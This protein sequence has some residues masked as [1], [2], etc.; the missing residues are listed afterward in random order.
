M[1]IQLGGRWNRNSIQPFFHFVHPVPEVP[2][3]IRGEKHPTPPIA[4]ATTEAPIAVST[5]R[6]PIAVATRAVRPPIDSRLLPSFSAFLHSVSWLVRAVRFRSILATRARSRSRRSGCSFT[7]GCI[8]GTTRTRRI[9]GSFSPA[10]DFAPQSRKGKKMQQEK[11]VDHDTQKPLEKRPG[12]IFVGSPNVGKRTL[13]SRL[14][15]VDFDETSE[16]TSEDVFHGWTIDT[17]YYTADVS[18]CVAHFHEGFSITLP[19]YTQLAALV[20]VFDM[21]DPSSLI[22]LQDWVS[23][24]DLQRFEILLCIGNKV[25][26]VPG[27]PVHSE[28]KRRLLKVEDSFADS[29]LEFVDYGISETEGSSFLGNEEPSLEIRRS[30]L[31]WCAENNIEFIESCACNAAFDKCLSADGDSQG[32]ERL[33]GALAAHMWP[34]MI[35]KLGDKIA[36]PSLPERED[37]S[38]EESEYEL[39]YEILSSGSA[40]P[41]DDT[42]NRWISATGTVSTSNAEVS[43]SQGNPNSNGNLENL[44]IFSGKETPPSTS[45]AA[46]HEDKDE[47]VAQYVEEPSG[48][49]K[50][51][52][53]LHF[54]FDE[55]EHLMSEIGNMRESLR[56]MPDFQRREMAA[57][58]ALKMAA[59]FGGGSDDEEEA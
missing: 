24:N 2:R 26:L 38:E 39:E 16:S 58:L 53:S 28:Y 7:G 10:V 14:I 4:V 21:N 25:D 45:T 37:L 27:H 13:L 56:L 1:D 51:G 44:N 59:M 42:D 31:E 48:V 22:A 17:K 8:S 32:V 54:D 47:G 12:I 23:H 9:H 50:A 15:S 41:W 43:V 6:A 35:L 11:D 19:T 18:I 3:V 40:E 52:E 46:L 57:N 55:L 36:E 49:A 20:M 29:R 5:T 33:F 34:G 30:C